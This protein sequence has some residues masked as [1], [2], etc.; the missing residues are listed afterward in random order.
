MTEHYE[1]ILYIWDEPQPLVQVPTRLT[2]R[3]LPAVGMEAFAAAVARAMTRSLDRSDQK[4]VSK[5][6][7]QEAAAHFLA[8]AANDFGY[9]P[10]WWQLAYDQHGDV[11]GFV[12][13]VIFPGC[14]KDGL[15]EGT[16]YYIGVVPEQRGN[17]YIFDLLLHTTYLLQKIG[18]W[19]IYCDTDILNRPMIQAFEKAGYRREGEA[20]VIPL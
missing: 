2:F 16:I 15:E 20:K 8:E 13:P 10:E 18:V 5:H 6:S 7:P 4:K 14:S 1:K 11:V 3:P 9:E 17:N 19:R 12:Q